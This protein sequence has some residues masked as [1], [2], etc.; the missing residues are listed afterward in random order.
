MGALANFDLIV[1]FFLLGAFASWIKSDLDV[2]QEIA[3]FLSIFLLLSL[4]LK[5]GHEVR[6]SQDLAGFFPAFG[7]G[8]LS[9]L[10]IPTVMFF[11]TKRR[12]GISDAAALAAA[13]IPAFRH[14]RRK[15]Y[16]G[17]NGSGQGCA[18]RRRTRLGTWPAA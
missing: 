3:K 10:V 17:G 1:L 11:L 14:F 8:L 9:C 16:I 18:P 2:P 12:L 7:L 5:G 13:Y 4:G 6:F 15:K